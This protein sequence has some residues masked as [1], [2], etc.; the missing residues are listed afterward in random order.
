MRV[1][2][3]RLMIGTS[4]SSWQLMVLIIQEESQ[5]YGVNQLELVELLVVLM[6]MEPS[7]QRNLYGLFGWR[8]FDM[9]GFSFRGSA[10]RESRGHRA[11]QVLR[12]DSNHDTWTC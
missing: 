6:V 10:G 1:G 8:L 7:Q 2:V 3:Q 11:A 9:E 4:S 5:L 12:W